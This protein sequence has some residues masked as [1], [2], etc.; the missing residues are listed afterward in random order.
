MRIFYRQIE[1][2]YNY[3]P[4]GQFY[5]FWFFRHGKCIYTATL[6]KE[7]YFIESVRY[8]AEGL[9][10]KFGLSMHRSWTPYT[11]ELIS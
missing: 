4:Y 9:M 3:N 2:R 8:I 1:V 11:D 10:S 7:K 6:F 5:N